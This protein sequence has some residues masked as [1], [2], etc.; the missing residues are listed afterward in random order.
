MTLLRYNSVNTRRWPRYHVHLPVYVAAST[1]VADIVVPGLVSELSRSGMEL[2][3]GVNLQPGDI[4][5]VEF[6]T[7]GKIR[8]AGVVRSRSGFCFGLEFHAVRTGRE[9]A[10]E[11][12]AA[13][14]LEAV[15]ELEAAPEPE[16][17]PE[18]E[19]TPELEAPDEPALDSFILQPHETDLREVHQK[20]DQS[21]ETVLEMRKCREE[22]ERIA[23]AL[24]DWRQGQAQRQQPRYPVQKTYVSSMYRPGS[25]L[26]SAPITFPPQPASRRAPRTYLSEITPAVLRCQ[27]GRSVPGRLQVISLAG[28]LLCLSHPLDQGSQVT[29]MFL[30]RRGSVVGMA[31]MLSP[32]SWSLQ[33]FRFVRLHDED[34]LRLQA[35]IQSSLD[36]KRRDHEQMEKHRAW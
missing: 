18:L 17:V 29:L 28:G 11:F 16:A 23:N 24:D 34:E 13:P 21:L 33:P 10:P 15:P 19:A 1:G 32:I 5:E 6:Q 8:V 22:V 12:E 36:R 25:P 27:D 2:Y 9:A 4:M 35:A 20:I 30:T 26:D 7:M 14:Q 31:E 3:G